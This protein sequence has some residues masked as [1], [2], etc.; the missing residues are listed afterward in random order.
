M[1]VS[2]NA[3]AAL[4]RRNKPTSF[5]AS[6]IAAVGLLYQQDGVGYHRPYFKDRESGVTNKAANGVQ[7]DTGGPLSADDTRGIIDA[8]EKLIPSYEPATLLEPFSATFMESVMGSGVSSGLSR[9][10]LL[11]MR[12]CLIG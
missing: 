6:L 9:R 1:A 10:K 4:I 7:I 12:P 5:I 11:K 2:H 3:Q 8:L